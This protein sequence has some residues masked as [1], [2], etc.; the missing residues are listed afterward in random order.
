MRTTTRVVGKEGKVVIAKP[1]RDSL[2][3]APGW[4]S[5]QRLVDD[6]VE[7]YFLPPDHRE[8]LKGCLAPYIKAQIPPGDAWQEARER[9]WSDAARRW[10]P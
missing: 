10:V 6:H 3:L 4:I 9:G 8:S 1:I 5:I 7:F 2:G